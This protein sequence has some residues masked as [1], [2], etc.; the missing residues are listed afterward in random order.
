LDKI[1]HNPAVKTVVENNPHKYVNLPDET[2][3]SMLQYF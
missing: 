1:Q 2:G 3:I